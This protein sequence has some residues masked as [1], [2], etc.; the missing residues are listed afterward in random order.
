MMQLQNV[1]L[2]FPDGDGRLIAVNDVSLDL[3][4]GQ[5]TALTGP[6]GSGKS[7]LLS[8]AATLITPD[9]GA[10]LV[11]GTD[12]T[13]LSAAERDRVRREQM[14]IVFQQAN[15]I[16]SLTAKEQL[17]VMQRLA[18]SRAERAA[19]D[20]RADELLAEVGMTGQANLRPHQLSGGQRQRVNIA[21]ALMSRPK[22]L[23]V[24]EPTSALDQEKGLEI[25]R[26]IADLTAASGLS[27]LFITHNVAQVPS[28]SRLLTMVDGLLC[29][30]E[31]T[32]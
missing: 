5:F 11:D 3:A 14:G 32:Q 10:V 9:N 22:V 15:L 23:L 24:D 2:S 4:P 19:T 26:L 8:V 27:T 17:L 25:T 29:G 30:D 20:A 6:S 18:G 13:A 31:L 1:T 7:S 28:G 12:V 21:R 16:A